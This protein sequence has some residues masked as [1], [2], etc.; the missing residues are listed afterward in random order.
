MN[1]V[2]KII[3]IAKEKIDSAGCTSVDSIA[4]HYYDI[5]IE[6]NEEDAAMEVYEYYAD[7]CGD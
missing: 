4:K 1:N 3:K 6:L 7:D 2:K 5:L